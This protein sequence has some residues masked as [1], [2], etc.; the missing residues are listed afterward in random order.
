MIAWNSSEVIRLFDQTNYVQGI[1]ARFTEGDH[2][3]FSYL[4]TQIV[5]AAAN[6]VITVPSTES[7]KLRMGYGVLFYKDV[8][9][10]GPSKV[11][12]AVD[13]DLQ[14]AFV[15]MN[16]D[17]RRV[18]GM[19]FDRSMDTMINNIRS[20]KVFRLLEKKYCASPS[21]S[22]MDLCRAIYGETIT[23]TPGTSYRNGIP[24]SA[25]SYTLLPYAQ[26]DEVP[27]LDE[28]TSHPESGY[29][30]TKPGSKLFVMLMVL[31]AVIGMVIW[32][33]HEPVNYVD[34][35]TGYLV[36]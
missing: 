35:Y 12:Y 8:N 26:T 22:D 23:T 11:F 1:G 32:V 7:F 13:F 29:E 24:G 36:R 9:F 19:K 6:K 2:G 34:P 33:T 18:G 5:D 3:D 17:D 25:S 21:I 30:L 15:G 20:M 31:V 14:R 10:R 4:T 27:P 28:D 16:V